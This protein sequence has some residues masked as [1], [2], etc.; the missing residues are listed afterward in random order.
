MK[1]LTWHVHGSWLTSFVQGRDTYLLPVN[2]ERDAEGRGRAQTW[3][4]PANAVEL[5]ARE[6]ADAP[7]DIVVLQRPEE[8]ELTKKWT[9]RTPGR[10]LPAV[11]VEHNTPGGDACRTRHPL[12]D[13]SD[14]PI[15]HVTHFNRLAWDCGSTPTRVIEHAIVDPGYR[16]TGE[17]QRTA[18]AINEPLRRGRAVGTDLLTYFAGAAPLDVFGMATD[19][20]SQAFS[21]SPIIGIADLPQDAMHDQLARRRVYLHTA[22]WTSLGLSLLEAMYL[23]MPVVALAATEAPRAIAPDAGVVSSDLESLRDAVRTFVHEPE[24]A[25]DVGLRARADVTQRY[26]LSRFLDQWD[27]ALRESVAG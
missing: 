12:A 11:Y 18:V 3:D 21:D 2:D 14:I 25:R 5:T 13:Q 7:L 22:R 9:G 24:L 17:L 23:G 20:L 4:W 27:A 19:G 8:I 16:Y 1:V 15:V 10:D 6:L 26:G